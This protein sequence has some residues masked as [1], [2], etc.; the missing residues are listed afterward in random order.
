MSEDK[1]LNQDQGKLSRRRFLEAGSAVFVAAAGMQA[2]QG[3]A[4]EKPVTTPNHTGV[5][6]GQPL[7]INKAGDASE[8]FVGVGSRDG[9]GRSATV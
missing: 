3:Q 9:C 4:Q 5:N 6:E 2:A 7:P 8:P 1:G